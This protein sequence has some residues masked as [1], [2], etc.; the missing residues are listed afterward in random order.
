MELR[1]KF[2]IIALRPIDERTLGQAC[3]TLDCD[4]I[5]LNLAI[6]Y[7]FPFKF[8]TFGSALDRGVKFEISYGPGMSSRDSEAR[9]NLIQNA[10]NLVRATRGRGIIISS[11]ASNALGC[12]APHDIVNMAI[13]WGLKQDVAMEC[14]GEA[15]RSV[16][17]AALLRKR[18]FKGAVDVIYA[19]PKPPPTETKLSNRKRKAQHEEV[20]DSP[21]PASTSK[22]QANKTHI[23]DQ[24]NP[25]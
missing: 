11:E 17:A 19:G 25:V 10:A 1:K 15:P 5:S 23:K 3:Q 6:R 8:K 12:R 4:I 7:P 20:D 21:M 18:S 16:V 24:S 2:D 22:K 13:I 14:V 9:K